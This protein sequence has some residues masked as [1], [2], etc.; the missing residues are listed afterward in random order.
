MKEYD[1]NPCAWLLWHWSS[2]GQLALCNPR[3]RQA[4]WVLSTTGR[5]KFKKQAGFKYFK[6]EYLWFSRQYK[7]KAY[8]SKVDLWCRHI[9]PWPWWLHQMETFSASLDLCAGNSSTP[10][11]F[12]AQRPLTW[13]FDVFF[14]LRLDKRLSKQSWGWWFETP[15]RSL[16]RHFDALNIQT[17]FDQTRNATGFKTM[18]GFR[19]WNLN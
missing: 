3:G 18:C 6:V 5:V 10:G 19:I 2:R 9:D 13:S 4:E 12:P 1:K 11:E 17:L 15:S 7:Q 14:D 8:T 16:R